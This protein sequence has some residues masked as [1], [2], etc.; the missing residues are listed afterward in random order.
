MRIKRK[1]FAFLQVVLIIGMFLMLIGFSNG[2]FI[3]VIDNV[4][5]DNLRLEA[6]NIDKALEAYAVNHKILK[7]INME[8]EDSKIIFN[9]QGSYPNNLNELKEIKNQ[10]LINNTTKLEEIKNVSSDSNWQY[11]PLKNNNDQI[12]GYKLSVNLS[13]GEVYISKGSHDAQ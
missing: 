9:Y 6:D 2:N 3:R 8:D 4:K 10:G 12:T 5:N 13:N 7:T 1:G 11:E